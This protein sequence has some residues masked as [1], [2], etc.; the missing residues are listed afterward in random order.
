MQSDWEGGLYPI[1]L[2][3]SE[4]YRIRPPV[5]KFPKGFFHPNVFSG[6]EVCLSILNDD[7]WKPSITMKQILLGIQDLLNQPNPSDAA[8]FEPNQ[9]FIKDP[10][11]Y[12]T[13]V[14]LEA[15]K[16]PPAI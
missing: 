9:L 8:N 16:Y 15:K 12:K 2:Q 1:T 5:C 10:A 7:G 6:G 3:F 14:Q 11:K 13:R 4:D